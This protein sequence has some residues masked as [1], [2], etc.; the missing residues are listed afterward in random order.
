MPPPGI[1]PIGPRIPGIPGPPGACIGG[2]PSLCR[3]SS[4]F[5]RASMFWRSCCCM[6]SRNSL[7]WSRP[8]AMAAKNSYSSG[9]PM[10]TT[11]LAGSF[12]ASGTCRR[13]SPRGELLPNCLSV[14]T[15]DWAGMYLK[16]NTSGFGG[17]SALPGVPA[18]CAPCEKAP[19]TRPART[20]A[21]ATVRTS[22]TRVFMPY[23]LNSAGLTM[24]WLRG[25]MLK[26]PNFRGLRLL[27]ANSPKV[28]HARYGPFGLL[29]RHSF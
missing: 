22:I 24:D 13:A 27:P 10:T 11:E 28:V 3:A 19:A 21:A 9:G 1:G 17:L 29:V 5:W 25:E 20:S 2:R 26:K 14:S 23:L 6:A 7:G 18:A 8:L 12:S 4:N 16:C 15:N